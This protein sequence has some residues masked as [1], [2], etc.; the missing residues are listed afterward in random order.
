MVGM[1]QEE[2]MVIVIMMMI[3]MMM[4]HLVTQTEPSR[5]V[6]QMVNIFITRGEG[7][8]CYYYE[9]LLNA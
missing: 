2:E 1:E 8:G 7:G 4:I 3:I 5:I 6:E 9:Q